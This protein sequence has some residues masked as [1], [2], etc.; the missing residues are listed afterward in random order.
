M[1]DPFGDKDEP[2][3]EQASKLSGWCI[4]QNGDDDLI[5]MYTEGYH[6]SY[7]WENCAPGGAY[8]TDVGLSVQSRDSEA[9]FIVL[10]TSDD[11][12]RDQ[13]LEYARRWG[14]YE[15]V[16]EDRYYYSDVIE[17]ADADKPD[18]NE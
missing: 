13:L 8:F 9:W 18:E 16:W 6:L 14:G 4:A 15:L 11:C 10:R 12:N 2:E 7:L 17:D 5:F 3:P 1:K